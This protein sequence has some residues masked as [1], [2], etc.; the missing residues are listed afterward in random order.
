MCSEDGKAHAQHLLRVTV[1]LA[2]WVAT[3]DQATTATSFETTERVGLRACLC[4]VFFFL[5]K[6][7][8]R[9]SFGRLIVTPVPISQQLSGQETRETLAGM[10]LTAA[11]VPLLQ[12]HL[13]SF[14]ALK[15]ANPGPGGAG[16]GSGA[17]GKAAAAA[18]ATDANVV[19][20]AAA[21]TG[22]L[23][24]LFLVLALYFAGAADDYGV[25]LQRKADG[26]QWRRLL[27]FWCLNPAVGFKSVSGAAR[28]VVLTSGTGICNGGL[29]GVAGAG[30]CTAIQRFTWPAA[31]WQAPCRPLSPLPRSWARRFPLRSRPATCFAPT[32]CAPAPSRAA[33][34]PPS[35]WSSILRTRAPLTSSTNSATSF[36]CGPERFAGLGGPP[37][38]DP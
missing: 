37:P 10:G 4:G 12:D 34:T 28:A 21:S 26:R 29:R 17:V 11:T 32:A 38:A 27:H 7:A 35:P 36:W 14:L 31:G 5:P 19:S 23:E 20:L 16:G 8:M 18:A 13:A 24:R 22:V 33:G 2:A 9:H 6:P 3:A 25:V 30:A 1:A 15:H